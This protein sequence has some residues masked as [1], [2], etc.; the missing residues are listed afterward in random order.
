MAN[1]VI[2][3]LMEVSPVKIT[4]ASNVHLVHSVMIQLSVINVLKGH[5]I[6]LTEHTY[7]TIVNLVIMLI[8]K[9]VYNV[10]HAQMENGQISTELHA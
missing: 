8:P 9:E 7:V 5:S 4:R 3:V 10:K 2:N 6:L 1:F